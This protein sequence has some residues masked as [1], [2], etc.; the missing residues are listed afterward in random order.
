[1]ARRPA[2]TL[3]SISTAQ[4]YARLGTVMRFTPGAAPEGVK[5]LH[6]GGFQIASS[7]E[8]R[9]AAA[10]PHDFD[11]ADVQYFER[12]GIAII[13][14]DGQRLKPV[15][16]SAMERKIVGSVRPEQQYRALG[17]RFV[18]AVENEGVTPDGGIRP[19]LSAR[20]S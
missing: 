10:V 15:L 20:L 14:R 19:G 7:R 1:M 12:F 6:A 8:F 18:S 17:R 9:S 2:P 3:T 5:R 16:E 4:P 11:G 13:R